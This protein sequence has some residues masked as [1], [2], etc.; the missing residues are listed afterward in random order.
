MKAKTAT[1]S[2]VTNSAKSTMRTSQKVNNKS[3]MTIQ[4]ANQSSRFNRKMNS[5][6]YTQRTSLNLSQPQRVAEHPQE[7]QQR[8]ADFHK[9]AQSSLL[10]DESTFLLIK[11][12]VIYKMMGSDLFIKYALSAM[13]MSYRL[14]GT[15]IVNAVV[16]NTAGSIFTAGVTIPDLVKQINLLEHKSQGGVACYVVEGLDKYDDKKFEE[17]F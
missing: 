2:V 8:P 3:L 9:A 15:K 10:S 6:K 12:Y 7:E 1:A 16:N 11:K 17:F 14:F 5:L 13:T 4:Q